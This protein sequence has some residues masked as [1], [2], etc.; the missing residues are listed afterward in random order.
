MVYGSSYDENSFQV[1]GVEI[2][3]NYFNEALAEPNTDAIEEVEILSLGAP[4]EYGNLTGAVYNIVT[5]QGTNEFHGDLGFYL[6][7]DGMTSDNSKGIT[8][9]DGS[10]MN[11][12][13]DGETR[14][15]WARDKYTDWSAQLGGPIVKDKLWFFASYA[16]QRDY[17]WDVG[18]DSTNPLT[19]I[20]SSADRYF[21]KLNAAQLAQAGRHLPPDD[22]DDA[23]P[24]STPR[25]RRPPPTRR[26]RPRRAWAT[27]GSCR[28]RPWSRSATR[29]STPT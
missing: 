15:P 17:Y 8:N 2:T 13:P 5:R 11:A 19:A 18:V 16:N 1:D 23:G 24:R 6:Q 21:F 3:D 4:A 29:A 26:R 9:P 25:P 27:P 28:T 22:R 10:F 20:R 12:C 14:C 7:S